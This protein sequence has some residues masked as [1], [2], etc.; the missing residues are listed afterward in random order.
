MVCG[1]VEIGGRAVTLTVTT[2]PD[3]PLKVGDLVIQVTT[4]A[5]VVQVVSD[6]S[7]R[8][9]YLEGKDAGGDD[10]NFRAFVNGAA[11]YYTPQD[12]GTL[13]DAETLTISGVGDDEITFFEKNIFMIF[14]KNLL[15][16]KV[17]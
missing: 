12:D 4:F 16:K 5:R 10:V 9:V 6:T 11:S 8:V 15:M 17:L 13:P 2:A 1:S 3:P 14:L 7:I